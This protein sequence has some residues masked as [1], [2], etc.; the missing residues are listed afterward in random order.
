MSLLSVAA[1]LRQF[2]QPFLLCYKVPS[3]VVDTLK[4]TTQVV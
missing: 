2:F 1:V 4:V 3:R